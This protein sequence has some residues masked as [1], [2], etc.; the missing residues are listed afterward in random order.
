MHQQRSFFCVNIFN[1]G[2]N[3]KGRTCA[4]IYN[5]K[6][7][8]TSIEIKVNKKESLIEKLLTVAT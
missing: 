2:S 6:K 1:N 4:K 7:I 5:A 3:D 8:F